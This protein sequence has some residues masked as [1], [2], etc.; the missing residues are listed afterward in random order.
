[1]VD[2]TRKYDSKTG[3]DDLSQNVVEMAGQRADVSIHTYS[4]LGV[5][6]VE[7]KLR[8][9]A[10]YFEVRF[11]KKFVTALCLSD[12]TRVWIERN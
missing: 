11:C 2:E 10:S 1:M 9:T 5:Y 4:V 7:H 8:H 12:L 6:F 3:R